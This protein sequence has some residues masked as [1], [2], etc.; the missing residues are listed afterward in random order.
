[1]YCREI[2]NLNIS[3]LTISKYELLIFTYITQPFIQTFRIGG[4][5]VSQATAIEMHGNA[6]RPLS[7]GIVVLFS[8][9]VCGQQKVPLNAAACVSGLIHN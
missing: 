8:M 6:N 2:Q 3:L 5:C 1:M 7:S 9:N 4:I